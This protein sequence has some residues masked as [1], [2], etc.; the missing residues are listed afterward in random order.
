MKTSSSSTKSAKQFG[1]HHFRG[2]AVTNITMKIKKYKK[3]RSQIFCNPG[4]SKGSYL[5]RCLLHVEHKVQDFG[6]S[7]PPFEHRV[8][9]VGL[10]SCFLSIGFE[11]L[12]APACTLSKGFE[13]LACIAYVLSKG[14]RLFGLALVNLRCL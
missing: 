1:V 6:L 7:S 12:G 4:V 13:T 10:S 14:F 8:R 3:V 5:G 2:R 11:I 9:D